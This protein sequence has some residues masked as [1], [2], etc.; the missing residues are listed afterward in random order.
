MLVADH[1]FTEPTSS[2]RRADVEHSSGHHLDRAQLLEP[3]QEHLGT[4]CE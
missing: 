1:L 2:N 4:I 3:F